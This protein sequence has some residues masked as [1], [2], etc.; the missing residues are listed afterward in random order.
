[1]ASTLNTAL[2]SSMVKSKRGNKGLRSISLEIGEVSPATLSR[3]EQGRVPDV[4]TFIKLCRWLDVTADSFITSGDE[5]VPHEVSNK[6]LIIAH[7]RSDSELDPE[8]V[9]TIVKLVDMAY[10]KRF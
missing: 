5:N 10:T 1:M 6:E 3:V 2:L 9:N 4:D 8:T 7:L